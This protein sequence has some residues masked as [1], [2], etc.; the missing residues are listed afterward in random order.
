MIDFLYISGSQTHL[1]SIR[2]VSLCRS[3]G[4][5]FLRKL[6]FQRLRGRSRRICRSGHPHCLVNIGASGKRI[7]DGASQAGGR[8]SEGLNLGRMIMRLIFKID[9]PFLAA[10]VHIDRD[11]NTAGVDF[12]RLL[13][14][15]QFPV[16][17]QLFCGQTCQIHQAEVFVLS[18]FV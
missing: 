2:A 13:L 11:D 16:G 4:Q 5:R 12:V 8:P 7:P 14:I 6:A 15:G 3:S 10:A 18:P 1:I 9:Q 17:F